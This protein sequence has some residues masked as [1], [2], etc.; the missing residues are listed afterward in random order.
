MSEQELVSDKIGRLWIPAIPQWRKYY[1]GKDFLRVLAHEL[2]WDAASEV[3]RPLSVNV[4]GSLSV[5]IPGGTPTDILVSH[6]IVGTLAVRVVEQ[7]PR[8]RGLLV[9]NLSGG[10]VFLG[11]DSNVNPATG[12]SLAVGEVLSLEYYTGQVWG[13]SAIW[14]TEV[15]VLEKVLPQEA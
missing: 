10:E 14:D 6:A 12:Y 9:K 1:L 8:R 13:V 2:G 3:W 7:N 4:D 15:C 5:G 11:P